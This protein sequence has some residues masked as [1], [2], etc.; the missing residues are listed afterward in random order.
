MNIN[1][2]TA[3]VAASDRRF[4]F[5]LRTLFLAITTICVCLGW[6]YYYRS[7]HVMVYHVVAL[8][9]A[10]ELDRLIGS[11]TVH[12][13]ENSPYLWVDLQ[14]QDLDRFL[15]PSQVHIHT[16]SHRTDMI[17]YWPLHAFTDAYVESFQMPARDQ[18]NFSPFGNHAGGVWGFLGVRQVAGH[19]IQFRVQCN[20]EH[21]SDTALYARGSPPKETA[22]VIGPIFYEGSFPAGALIFLRDSKKTGITCSF[23]HLRKRPRIRCHPSPRPSCASAADATS[24]NPPR[25]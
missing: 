7:V 20:V 22:K 15:D 3:N 9:D 18:P 8:V 21:Q 5:G 6:L 17:S 24:V 25:P 12:S 10:A 4:R 2:P 1:S 11:R 16:L 23:S 19:E 14:Q 13:V